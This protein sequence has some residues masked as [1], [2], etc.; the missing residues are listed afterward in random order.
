MELPFH[1]AF[2]FNGLQYET[3]EELHAFA[4]NLQREGDEYEMHIG[5]FIQAWLDES[6][7]LTVKTSGSTGTP[8]KIK[9]PKQAMVNSAKAT[10]A[11]FKLAAGTSA[12]LCLPANYIAGKMMLVRAMVMGWDLHVVAP[13]K[14]ALTQYD[15]DYDFVAM[16]PYQVHHSLPDLNKVK[17]LIIG[18]GPVSKELEE[19]LQLVSTEAF[20]TY[21]M[22]ETITHIAVR[23]INGPAR[24]E[25]FSALPN[26]KFSQDERDCLVISAPD[27]SE[28][29][30]ITND[31]VALQS[32]T[33]FIW[34]GRYDNVINSGGV[35]IFPEKVEEQLSEKITE[36]FIIASEKNTELGERV[37]L[38][39]ETTSETIPDYTK[40]FQILSKYER[41]KK[42]ITLSKFP[43]TETG[44]IKRGGVLKLLRKYK[45]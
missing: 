7:T 27:I 26:V 34:L 15:N 19:Q 41:P 40:T 10:A 39:V 33:S 23:R 8:K 38:V 11:Y 45:K 21:G 12:L 4:E 31:V 36:P 3:K 18:G 1:S 6:D 24:S 14:D 42:I 5:D 43:Y 30:V 17:K 22:T 44:K 35:K 25:A 9:L 13:E 32:P 37:V 2:T 16:V 28:E 29:K 20:G